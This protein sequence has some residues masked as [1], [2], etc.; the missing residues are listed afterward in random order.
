M[1]IVTT[2]LLVTLIRPSDLISRD[3]YE[4]SK[5]AIRYYFSDLSFSKDEI[6]ATVSNLYEY[7]TSKGK[8]IVYYNDE[9][10]PKDK[11][12]VMI[13]WELSNSDKKKYKLI[14]ADLRTRIPS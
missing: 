4:D 3:M 1:I 8:K 7:L 9:I 6:S 5:H 11:D 12:E 14:F 10:N 2:I 13:C